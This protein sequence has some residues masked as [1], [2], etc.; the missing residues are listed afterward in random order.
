MTRLRRLNSKARLRRSSRTDSSRLSSKQDSPPAA[1]TRARHLC[2]AP[3][4]VRGV[5]LAAAVAVLVPVAA[6]ARTI[7]KARYIER[8]D[9]ICIRKEPRYRERQR[10]FRDADGPLEQAA[11]LR[12]LARFNARGVD[13]VRRVPRPD[14]DARLAAAWVQGIARQAHFQRRAARAAA[15][16]D[17]RSMEEWLADVAVQVDHANSA[18]QR[19]GFERCGH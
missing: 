3:Q 14:Q 4:V 7:P 2:D 15:R 11:A 18:A 9:A 1:T 17:N 12:A 13:R 8:V 10:D 19:F 16:G 5:A 6:T